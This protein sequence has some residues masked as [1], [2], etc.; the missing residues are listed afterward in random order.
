[1]TQENKASI[2]ASA[3]LVAV[4]ALGA[5]AMKAYHQAK[6]DQTSATQ[7]VLVERN[8]QP[9]FSIPAKQDFP[10]LRITARNTSDVEIEVITPD[11][12]RYRAK[13]VQI[14]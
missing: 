3:I 10:P 12:K 2:G 1:M 13:W 6:V 8:E 4:I 14:P 9:I 7:M 11:G 5:V